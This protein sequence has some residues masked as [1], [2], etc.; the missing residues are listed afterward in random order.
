MATNNKMV[1]KKVPKKA[2]LRQTIEYEIQLQRMQQ[3][4]KNWRTAT[5]TAENII[6]P[7]RIE[8]YRLYKDILL[9]AHISA[10]WEARKSEIMGTNFLVYKKGKLQEKQTDFIQRKWFYDF[11]DYTLDSK[12]WGFSLIQFGDVL[13]NEFSDVDLVPRP[14]VRPEFNI[15]V[16]MWGAMTGQ[17]YTE[18]PYKEWSIPI[19]KKEDLGIM[20]KLGPLYIW[21]K[22]AFECWAQYC[23]IF[24]VPGRVIKTDTSD[25]K[26]YNNARK[27]VKEMGSTL[28]A[29]MDKDDEIEIL[30]SSSAHVGDT[31]KG[32]IEM[33]NQ[34]ISKLILGESSSMDPKA[35]VGSS[36]IHEK[37]KNQKILQDIVWLENIFKYQLI[38]FLNYHTDMFENCSIRIE[39]D[40]QLTLQEKSDVI[41]MLLEGGYTIPDEYI[42]ETFGIPTLMPIKTISNKDSI[43]EV[44]T[45]DTV[46]NYID[47]GIIEES[48]TNEIPE[49]EEI[50]E[51]PMREMVNGELK[52]NL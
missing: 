34:E 5:I 37:T 17:N 2:V 30:E 33:C 27:M 22:T 13:D 24:G 8:L 19:G 29:V 45:N 52:P 44:P 32:L 3:D 43:I 25:V 9:D 11:I 7:Y 14:Y 48:T 39:N 20:L 10:V 18:S 40:Q 38:P 36:Q 51:T 4:L 50:D 49:P 41:K 23:Q 16:Q 46:I 21:K 42:M 28:G 26:A 35:F 47:D 15:V 6:N 31:F 12:M 1:D